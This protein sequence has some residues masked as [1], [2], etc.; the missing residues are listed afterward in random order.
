MTEDQLE[1]ETLVWLIEAGY[2]HVYG[3]NIAL[4]GDAPE[5]STYTQVVLVE[6]LRGAI[7]QLNPLLP[8]DARED[9]LQQVLNLDTP[10][11]LPSNRLFHRMLVNGVPVEYQ[12]DG[13]TRGDFVRLIDFT[14]VAANEWLAVSIPAAPTSSCSSMACRWCCSN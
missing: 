11:L 10:V 14:D 12:R 2:S 3:P 6:R 9:A 5:R 4:D 13:E 7:S 8:H 1:Q